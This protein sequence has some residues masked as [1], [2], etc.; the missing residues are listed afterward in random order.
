MQEMQFD[1]WLLAGLIARYL[2][3]VLDHSCEYDC[4]SW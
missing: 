3:P 4:L 1:F 2:M